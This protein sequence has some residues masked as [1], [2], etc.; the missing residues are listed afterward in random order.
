MAINNPYVPG[1]PF[2]YDL[3]WII[4]ELKEHGNILSTL[5][6][7]IAAAVQ[8]AMATSSPVYYR[9]A[10]DLIA[11][12]ALTPSLAYIEGFYESGDLGANLYYVTSDYNDVLAAD[13]YL[14]LTGA[15]R[16]AIP[17][18]M[19]PAVTPEMFGALGDGVADDSEAVQNAVKYPCSIF[20]KTYLISKQIDCVSNTNIT[21][22][23]TIL[24]RVPQGTIQWEHPAVFRALNCKNVMITDLTFIG[25]GAYTDTTVEN[26]AVIKVENSEEIALQGMKFYDIN[27]GYAIVCKASRRLSIDH[28]TMDRY[29]FAGIA[30]SMGCDT[31]DVSDNHLRNIMSIRAYNYPITLCSRDQT[32][33]ISKNVTC[34]R[35]IIECPYPIWEG[36]DSHGGENFV[37]SENVIKGALT[38]IALMDQLTGDLTWIMKNCTV[39]GNVIDLGTDTTHGRIANN[40][41]IV[42]NGDNVTVSNNVIKNAGKAC[43]GYFSSGAIF[44]SGENVH[45]HNNNIIDVV[46][47]VIQEKS[48][49][50]IF[51]TDNVVTKWTWVAPQSGFTAHGIFL[52]ASENLDGYTYAARN[53]INDAP[54]AAI[55]AR[56]FQSLGANGGAMYLIDNKIPAANNAVS[57]AN[58]TVTSPYHA[59]VGPYYCGK[60]GDIILESQPAVGSSLGWICT[61]DYDPG[62]SNAVWAPL[63]NL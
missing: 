10:A 37:V 62:N 57:Y 3:K 56:P 52:W 42:V 32:L 14:T 19:A 26:H 50:N 46:G 22:T 48:G 23:G 63:P 18:I 6:E 1:D 25:T 55:L 4:K 20:T 61:A 59:I 27:A 60:K 17:I 33:I 45:V 24:D 54:S 31:V 43:A 39:T 41:G 44:V 58:N 15:N 9:T 36:I 35:N 5:D 34:C 47:H 29:T 40:S 21:G 13:F 12:D 2:S 38:G 30:L 51:I 53:Q 7:R 11:S 49:T 28:N 8:A 16:W